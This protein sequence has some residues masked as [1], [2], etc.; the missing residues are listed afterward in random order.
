MAQNRRVVLTIG[1]K[2]EI[3]RLF[4]NN[5]RSSR[6]V[7]VIFNE[8]HY[9]RAPISHNTAAKINRLFASTGAVFKTRARRYNLNQ[10]RYPDDERILA[11]F[12]NNPNGSIRSVARILNL[13]KN[14]VWRCLKRNRIRAFKPKFL[15]TLLNGDFERRFEF[16]LWLQGNYLNDRHFLKNIMFTDEATFTTNGVV[17]SQN[18]R[19][20]AAENPNWV[21]NSKNQYSEKVNVWC[22]ILNERIVGPFFLDNLNGENFLH[23]LQS[24]FYDFLMELP[25]A[26]R[27]NLYFQLDGAPAHNSL[28]VRNFLNVNFPMKWIGRNSPLEPWPPRSPDITPCDFFLW[29][30]LKNKVYAT[31]PR[32]RQELC[33][34]IRQACQE[35]TPQ[36][37]RKLNLRLR[38][39]VEKCIVV[40]GSYVEN[41]VI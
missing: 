6:Q 9:D 11:E 34:R 12:R 2:V 31:R 4:G 33:I 27:Q 24:D 15:H 19:F 41:T 39:I 26:Q 23:F 37:L 22:G 35:I 30:Y 21:I 25:L 32:N 8:R 3:I 17:S 1:E 28:I 20:W 18:C 40:E 16:C 5:E 13:T 10:R 29:G 38:R 14:K 7:S 36:T